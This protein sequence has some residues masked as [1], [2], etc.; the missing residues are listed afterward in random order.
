MSADEFFS[1][2]SKKVDEEGEAIFLILSRLGSALSTIYNSSSPA[3]RDFSLVNL[4]VGDPSQ[5]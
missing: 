3:E 5:S 2:L 1:C 4:N